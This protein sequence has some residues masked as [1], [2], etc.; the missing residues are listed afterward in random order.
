M[1]DRPRYRTWH[2]QFNSLTNL[3]WVISRKCKNRSYG[4]DS[5]YQHPSVTKIQLINSNVSTCFEYIRYICLFVQCQIFFLFSRLLTLNCPVQEHGMF[6]IQNDH[7]SWIRFWSHRP[8]RISD[9]CASYWA[10][11]WD[12]LDN[13]DCALRY[14]PSMKSKLIIGTIATG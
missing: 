8:R 7:R 2:S 6:H 14:E 12:N 1:T 13:M 4:S 3:C 5:P 10:I 9:L 11:T